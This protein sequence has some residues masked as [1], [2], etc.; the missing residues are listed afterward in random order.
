MNKTT[1]LPHRISNYWII[2]IL[3][4]VVKLSLHFVTN[5]NYELHRDEMLF[6]NMADH[7]DF[8]YVSVP[9]FTGFLA[10]IIK[11]IF[12]YSVFGIRF[13]PA[14]LG[15]A[16]ILIIAKIV[17]ESG[18]GV[19]AL[20]IAS[21]AFLLSPGFLIFNTLFTPNATEQ[22]L[23]LLITYLIFRMIGSNNPKQWV[24]TGIFIGIAFLNKYSIIFYLA[25]FL[26]AFIF[27]SYRHLL[28]SKY[29]YFAILLASILI[30]PNI[31]WQYN[32]NWPVIHHMEELKK[33][34]LD[35]MDYATFF[36]DIFSL[37][38]IYTLVWLFGLVS[39]LFLRREKKYRCIGVASLIIIL[40]FL[41]LNGKGYYIQGVIPFLFAIGGYSMEKYF[42]GRLIWI[43]YFVLL[44]CILISL[45]ALPFGLPLL[46]F[47]K[48]S[49]Y[50]AKTKGFIIYPFYR[51][52]DGEAHNMSQAYADMTGWKELAG[53][54]SK[55]YLQL[56]KEEQASCIIYCERN[57]GYADAVHFYGKK[58]NLPDAITFLESHVLWAP[59][60]IPPGPVIYI[61]KDLGGFNK[62]FHEIKQVGSVNNKYF[63]EN[64]LKVFLCRKNKTD[65]QRIYADKA[66]EEKS[67]YH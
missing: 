21:A 65:V 63:R 10:Y 19:L 41:F 40:L 58:Y 61:N 26:I 47:D 57:Y 2:T 30:I 6:F 53:Y 27:S 52:E 62:L 34:Q 60:T 49:C 43:S 37:N 1:R 64:G 35:K 46:S 20:I 4:I 13:I 32:H 42:K 44:I 66:K 51:W 15:A 39:L 9:P 8:G 50:S 59:D 36:V 28:T 33:T 16:S 22:F 48:L 14:I 31:F 5:T 29:F 18:G 7:P 11:V 38:L 23:W 55:A 56:S 67:I 25:G 54:V 24:L 45:V 17:K 12:G 3:L